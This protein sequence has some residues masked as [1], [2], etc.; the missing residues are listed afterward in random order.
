[1]AGAAGATGPA[2]NSSGIP[3]LVDVSGSP[4][5]TNTWYLNLTGGSNIVTTSDLNA[6]M[7]V[8]FPIACT[9]KNLHLLVGSNG[10]ANAVTA[11]LFKNGSAQA[12]TSGS[13]SVGTSGTNTCTD[14]S[15]TVAVAIGD[16]V[17][18]QLTDTT[19]TSTGFA[20]S[21]VCQ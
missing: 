2:G 9:L 10:T 7:G 4:T 13:C 16:T 12:L 8:P 15:H 1:M 20:I 21:A 6:A 11:T 14:L 3:L 17:V 5:N 19:Q 18:W